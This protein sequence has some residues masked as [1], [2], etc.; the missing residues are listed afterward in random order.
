MSDWEVIDSYSRAQAIADGVLVDVTEQ[1]RNSAIRYPVAVSDTLFHQ[2]IEP[3]EVLLKQ[4]Q[5]INGRLS[6]VFMQLIVAIK[7]SFCHVPDI[8][9]SVAF[10]MDTGKTETVKV[11]ATI[12]GGDDGKP[13]VTI[14]LEG[15]D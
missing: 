4:G 13:V 7:R 10:L 11:W 1:A 12:N 14:M 3:S 5:S 6:D 15:E 8:H 9:F 2:Y